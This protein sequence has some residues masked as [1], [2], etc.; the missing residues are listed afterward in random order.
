MGVESTSDL[1]PMLT[2][3]LLGAYLFQKLLAPELPLLSLKRPMGLRK[4]KDHVERN[5]IKIWL[6]TSLVQLKEFLEISLVLV[7]VGTSS[8]GEYK[9]L[10]QFSLAFMAVFNALNVVNSFSYA[11][12]IEK[13]DI[14][15]LNRKAANEMKMG[16][17]FFLLV[18]ASFVTLAYFYDVFARFSLPQSSY[19]IFFVILIHPF[20]N[21]LMGPLVQLN[22]HYQNMNFLNVAQ[23]V[24][25]CLIALI[26]LY[27][28]FF[29]RF[30]LLEFIIWKIV[31]EI[32][33][34]VSLS[35]VLF[36]KFDYVPPIMSKLRRHICQK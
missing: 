31:V 20:C 14:E 27:Y 3:A 24:K 33:F 11:K 17:Q 19:Q 21:L 30:G 6:N 29:G 23:I 18:L 10:M 36:K 35:Y 4:L 2:I 32:I 26:G 8:G 25:I 15:I 5:D 1:Y 7:A 22:I 12:I 13:G 9:L 34:I 16:L 28:L